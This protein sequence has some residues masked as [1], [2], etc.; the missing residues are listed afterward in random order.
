MTSH[1]LDLLLEEDTTVVSHSLGHHLSASGWDPSLPSLPAGTEFLSKDSP[2]MMAPYDQDWGSGERTR[3]TS[4]GLQTTAVVAARV[5]PPG[6]L[7]VGATCVFHKDHE[8]SQ[9]FTSHP[10][11]CSERALHHRCGTAV[12]AEDIKL[13][14]RW[15]NRHCNLIVY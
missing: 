2:W 12:A 6:W 11:S 13:L 7:T 10:C 5:T 14:Y 9:S 1:L 15:R 3:L 4:V 8:A